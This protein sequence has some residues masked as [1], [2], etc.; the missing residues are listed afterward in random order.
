MEFTHPYIESVLGQQDVSEYSPVANDNNA[1]ELLLQ[2]DSH[3]Q[4][5]NIASCFQC[6]D[7][8]RAS[9]KLS[10][11]TDQH[12][13]LGLECLANGQLD[14]AYAA[15]VQTA[16]SAAE[17]DDNTLKVFATERAVNIAFWMGC[18]DKMESAIQPLCRSAETLPYAGGIVA[19]VQHMAGQS[20][21]AEETARRAI[22]AGF[23]DP[24]TLH[25]VAHCLYSLGRISECA[26]WIRENRRAAVKCST[27][28][29]THFEFHLALCLIDMKDIEGLGE[30]VSGPLWGD[31]LDDEKDDYWAATGVLNVL[32]K[33][34]LRGLLFDCQRDRDYHIENVMRHLE[35]SASASRSK[36]F[37]LCILRW[38]TGEFREMWLQ[39]LYAASVD[40]EVFKI[41]VDAISI[42]YPMGGED[43]MTNNTEKWRHVNSLIFPVADH[44]SELGASPE[45]REVLEE[46]VG[47][48]LLK[49]KELAPGG[50]EY[51][52]EVDDKPVESIDRWLE[53]N[54]RPGVSYY[55][56]FCGLK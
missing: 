29:R 51:P 7:A 30:L 55:D 23:D 14:K 40:N 28:M 54:R 25:A 39:K 16:L 33:A 1:T 36:V 45:Q 12:L 53:R 18:V 41:M 37:S 46:F 17:N 27:F 13:A 26:E 31:L 5:G 21:H 4:R 48:I 6:L 24:W 49:N 8:A 11:N 10:N 22:A 15:F 38:A 19:F 47:T 34:E 9:D 3:W 32:W 44:L 20:A 43:G 52:K 2:A 35:Q 50:D 56:Q 42:I